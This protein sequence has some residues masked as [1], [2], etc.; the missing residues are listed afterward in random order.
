M[1]FFRRETTRQWWIS[2][3]SYGKHYF[4]VSSIVFVYLLPTSLTSIFFF[5]MVFEFERR[6]ACFFII[7]HCTPSYRMQKYVQTATTFS[8]ITHLSIDDAGF[9][10]TTTSLA[11]ILD[12][13]TRLCHLHLDIGLQRYSLRHEGFHRRILA[14]V[15]S[16]LLNNKLTLESLT[17]NT[18][19]VRIM[20]IIRAFKGLKVIV[21]TITDI[22]EVAKYNPVPMPDAWPSLEVAVLKLR[23]FDP[24]RPTFVEHFLNHQFA[25]LTSL[26]VVGSP[27]CSCVH[28][29]LVDH[30]HQIERLSFICPDEHS[31]FSSPYQ[32]VMPSMTNTYELSFTTRH[33]P[34]FTSC[35]HKGIDRLLLYDELMPDIPFND[36]HADFMK[37]VA[38]E[39]AFPNVEH[40][41]LRS[42]RDYDFEVPFTVERSRA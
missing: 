41:I 14:I 24:L 37:R 1:S 29:F 18:C 19:S 25:A 9:K 4:I 15:E 40:I 5:G 21:L 8:Q 10:L 23:C 6:D 28:N 35:I 38:K 2:V 12:S 31:F 17:L 13:V 34:N 27:L 11:R 26:S 30:E 16:A 7:P 3:T 39:P 20:E 33:Y 36:Y 22:F 32:F 42:T